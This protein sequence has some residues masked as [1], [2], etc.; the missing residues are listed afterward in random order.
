LAQLLNLA[1]IEA[2]V[3]ECCSREY[4]EQ[5]IRAGVLEQGTVDL[6]TEI[7]VGERMLREGQVHHG[8]ELRFDGRGHRIPLS[9][10]T[11]GRAITL[12][13]QQEVVK[14]LI[15]A[16]L[17]ADL[18]ILFEVEDVSVSGLDSDPVISFRHQ[19]RQ[20]QLEC[21]L[22]A[23]CDGFHGVCREAI[24]EDLLTT[25]TR[26]YPFG[27]LGI[28]AAVAPS[29]H[30]L[31][32]AY[33]KRGF[34]LHSLRSPELSRLYIQCSP[35]SDPADWSAE[36]IWE[37]LHTRL[38]TDDDWT[39]EEGPILEKSVTGMRAVVVEPMQYERL[40]LA[41]DA[42]HIVPPTGAKGLN[43]AV[44]D[45]RVLAEAVVDWYRRNSETGLATYS[46]TCLQ[47][48]WRAQHFAWWMT[49]MLH[50]IDS[51]DSEVEEKLQ[52]SQLNYVC[53]STAAA[54]SLAENYVGLDL[55]TV[56]D[57]LSIGQAKSQGSG[58]EPEPITGGP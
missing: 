40:Y 51:D 8:I 42:A 33:H 41:G 52:R 16:R 43:L 35:Y 7:G 55:P 30:E 48:V 5:R 20:E 15:R 36:R 4:V 34:A 56:S 54:T 9:D 47:R 25:Y 1:G 29:T 18:P 12:Y 21:D 24:P 45:V 58:S 23:G 19:G 10:L 6:L 22:I 46:A 38:A 32:Y 31:I 37:E 57:T 49:Q 44:A 17:G 26:D 27:W 28:L 13:G 53:S 39:L 2:V 3:L 11:G 14:D 50:R